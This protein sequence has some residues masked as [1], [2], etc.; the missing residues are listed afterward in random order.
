MSEVEQD[1]L[2]MYVIAVYDKSSPTI[3]I[4]DARLYHFTR[5][6]RSCDSISSIRGALVEHI[7][8]DTYKAGCF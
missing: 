1:I 5:K 4:N 7:K 3:N 8:R 2:E 6:Q